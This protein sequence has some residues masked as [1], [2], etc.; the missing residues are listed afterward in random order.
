MLYDI[1]Y[2]SNK[3]ESMFFRARMEA[4]VIIVPHKDSEEILR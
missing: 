4:G 3:Q 2:E 1:A